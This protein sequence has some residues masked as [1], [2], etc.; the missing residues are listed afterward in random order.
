M[1]IEDE[2]T[3]LSN[4]KNA[5]KAAINAKGVSV[6]NEPFSQYPAKIMNISTVNNELNKTFTENGY[7]QVPAGKTGFGAININV[8]IG[9]N[10]MSLFDFKWSDHEL[11]NVS[12][13]QSNFSDL[14]EEMYPEAF[15]ELES[16][17]AN[18]STE[19]VENG[20]HFKRS[21]KGYKIVLFDSDTTSAQR[22]QAINEIEDAYLN[23]GTAW[24]YV[25]DTV[26]RCFKLPRTKYGFVGYRGN[27]VGDY[28]PETLPNITGSLS[29]ETENYEIFPTPTTCEGALSTE[30]NIYP[31]TVNEIDGGQGSNYGQPIKLNFDASHSSSI[32]QD[33]APVQQRANEM[34]LYFFIGQYSQSTL[35]NVIG[36]DFSMINRKIDLNGENAQFVHI[37][38]SNSTLTSSSSLT[39]Y[40]NGLIKQWGTLNNVSSSDWTDVPDNSNGLD[41]STAR[42]YT[43]IVW[44]SNTAIPSSP[45]SI[46]S[47]IHENNGAYNLQVAATSSTTLTNLTVQWW[48]EGYEATT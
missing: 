4:T 13:V 24:F 18:L 21:N 37:T 34:Y 33:N 20:V 5:I 16:E 14:Y 9:N 42:I 2:L 27:A 12:W 26:N 8:P 10:T 44:D 43:Q 41:Y 23:T 7:Y 38:N 15:A 32:Y 3:L 46:I 6:G 39:R 29:C 19:E 1:S 31:T 22:T 28:V 40:S 17:S 36:A 30:S 45:V 35:E 47:R 25:V 11:E 48:T